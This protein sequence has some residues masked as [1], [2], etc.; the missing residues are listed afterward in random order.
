MELGRLTL[1]GARKVAP[2]ALCWWLYVVSGV[3][4]LRYLNVPMYSCL[5]RS[6]TLLVVLGEARLFHRRPSRAAAAALAA[7][8]GGAALA[9]ASDLSFSLPGYCWTGVCVCSTAAYLLL[10]CRLRE[11]TGERRAGLAGPLPLPG[12]LAAAG[13]RRAA[14]GAR[15]HPTRPPRAPCLLCVRVRVCR[16]R[17][18]H[19]AAVQQCAGAGAH[20]NLAGAGHA[21]AATGGGLPPAT[22]PLLPRFPPGL[23]L[24]GL[25]AQP[26]HLQ[27]STGR[28][29]TRARDHAA[30]SHALALARGPPCLTSHT[31]TIRARLQV[32]AGQLA[33]SHK[34]DGAG[35]GRGYHC[36]WVGSVWGCEVRG[37]WG[38]GVLGEGR[39]RERG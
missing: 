20:G 13:M 16:H 5:R 12:W 18:A 15:A 22:G 39:A 30:L 7:M 36:A 2:L 37:C 27:A 24:P 17:A 8:V 9:G 29:A 31:R 19:A 1:G 4:A 38:A 10:I 26:R 28:G 33:A 11:S 32:H 25:P 3:T 14:C 35:Q 34:R 21:R 23:M 6:T